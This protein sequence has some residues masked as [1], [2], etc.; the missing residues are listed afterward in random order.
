MADVGHTQTD[1]YLSKMERKIQTEYSKAARDVQDKLDSYLKKFEVKDEIK[2][3]QLIDGEISQAEYNQW[4]TGQIMMGKRWEEMR[5]TLAEDFSHT[6]Q[7]AAS[8]INGYTPEVYALNHNYGTFEVE[9]GSMMDTSYTLYDRQTVERLMR[10]NPQLLPKAKVN[11]PID[12]RWNKKKITSAVTQGILQG[13]D[14][15]G[16]AK[17]L[18]TVSDMNKHASIRNARTMT[19]SAENAGRVDSYRRA[20]DMGINMKQ[21]WLATLDGRTRHSHRQMDGEKINV[22]KDKWHPAKFSNGCRY[23]GDPQGPA[24]EVYNCRCTIIAQVDG[25]DFDVTDVSLRNN[26]KLGRMS[27]DEWKNEH[28]K[29]TSTAT[30]HLQS[31][32]SSLGDKYAD[33]METVLE[34][35][36]ESDVK[37]IYYKYGD[38]LS[39]VDHKGSAAYFSP[40]DGKVHID[41]ART[42]EGD[43]LHNPYQTTFH[44][45]AHSIDWV[46][47]HDVGGMW[48]SHDYKNGL[49]DKTLRADYDKFAH[50]TV[51]DYLTTTQDGRDE[52][53][54]R[55]RQIDTGDGTCKSLSHQ[56]RHGEI[57]VEDILSRPDADDILSS[58][59]DTFDK[60]NKDDLV[61]FKLKAE[62]LSISES[63]SISDII[64]AMTRRSYPLGAGHGANY[65]GSWIDG[66]FVSNKNAALEFFAE[67]CDSKAANP[68]ALAQMRRVFPDSVSVVEEMFKEIMKL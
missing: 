28:L 52:F 31:V 7:I 61:I 49:L 4:R 38:R 33:A 8:I 3:K 22:A 42:A 36:E 53:R 54:I 27:Y 18:Q 23:P 39:V 16:I 30:A 24:W 45:F 9:K 56:L 20:K 60:L 63:G 62:H 2:K 46:A 19:T 44:E 67:V 25:V 55:L 15:R 51:V 12:Q 43:R 40:M 17:R 26:Y 66:D 48:F 10:E 29:T 1:E 11:I 6:N 32:R 58:L 57:A 21:V 59:V 64:E 5:D 34:F 68:Q 37:S 50:R 65:W 35:T 13:E 41:S 47:G 14:I